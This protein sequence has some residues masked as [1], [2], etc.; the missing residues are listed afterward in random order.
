MDTMN[1]NLSIFEP[2]EPIDKL[3]ARIKDTDSLVPS[4]SVFTE[5]FPSSSSANNNVMFD[6]NSL[7]NQQGNNSLVGTNIGGNNCD[8]ANL[9]DFDEIQ[10]DKPPTKKFKIMGP[11]STK[12]KIIEVF[13]AQEYS[14]I[15]KYWGNSHLL[16]R[17]NDTFDKAGMG[18]DELLLS[19][20]NTYLYKNNKKS[21]A[22]KKG[23]WRPDELNLFLEVARDHG[24]GDNWGLFSSYIPGRR[25]YTCQQTYRLKFIKTG[26]IFDPNYY[27]GIDGIEYHMDTVKVG[28]DG[29]K[30]ITKKI[31]N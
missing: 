22:V 21:Q 17:T 16:S 27:I 30:Y 19:N 26:L 7:F 24:V 6:N 4:S 5:L 15:N 14:K 9:S 12:T 18:V 23:R 8:I 31:K 20:I 3:L 1:D 2:I 28:Q 10:P 11:P 25:G 13:T 29:I